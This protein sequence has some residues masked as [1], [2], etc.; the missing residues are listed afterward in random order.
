[1]IP[2]LYRYA[3]DLSGSSR[4][5]F[6]TGEPHAIGM[7]PVRVIAPRQG[8]FFARSVQVMDAFTRAVLSP[9]QYRFQFMHAHASRLTGQE[10]DALIVITDHTVGPIVLITYQALG[11][12]YSQPLAAIAGEITALSNDTRGVAFRN[13]R[14]RPNTYPPVPHLHEIGDTYDW[15]YI[16]TA[17][18]MLMAIMSLAE[19]ASYDT[20]LGFIDQQGNLRDAD[21]ASLAQALN[22]HITNYSNPHQVTLAQL[23][24]YSATQVSALIAAQ[25]GMRVADDNTLLTHIATH[26]ADGNIPHDDTAADVGGY[27]IEEADAR[28][29]AIVLALDATLAADAQAMAAHAADTSNPHKVTLEQ[30]DALSTAQI[31]DVISTAMQPATSQL[32]ACEA[33]LDAHITDYSNPHQT[34]LS[35]ISGWDS[36]S[37]GT[38][39]S[40]AGAHI[41]STANPHQLTA[42]QV[43][44]LTASQI[45]SNIS[46]NLTTPATN[47]Y[48]TPQANTINGHAGDTNNPHNTT[49]AMLGGWTYAQWQAALQAAINALSY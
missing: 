30:I 11:G 49:P 8:L 47:S 9:L 23:D 27:T 26:A 24:M 34:T 21:I 13:I 17:I 6:V 18:E 44:T 28:L 43:G 15:D 12:E 41:A 37:I 35:Q 19:N 14:N 36:G 39:N 20:V 22:A 3:P 29:N 16:V 38:L 1:M 32:A 5:N 46:G 10:V 42:R 25:S 33:Q 40:E 45:T 7:R 48:L 2:N 31:G 4:R